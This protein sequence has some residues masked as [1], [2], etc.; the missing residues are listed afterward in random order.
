MRDAVIVSTARSPIG[1]AYK[2]AFNATHAPTLAGHAIRAAVARSG[3]SPEMIDDVV[4]G[5]GLQQG[6]QVTIARTAALRAGLPASVAAMSLD[7]QCAS[8]LMA[9]ATAAKQV[10]V[11]RMEVV[12]A[13]GVES[14][15][16][17]QTKEMR[18]T[19]D[20]ELLAAVPDIYMPMLQTAEVVADRYGIGRDVQDAYALQS[21]QRTAVALTRGAFDQEIVP[22]DVVMAQTDRASG[23]IRHVAL[24]IDADE[25]PRPETSAEGLATRNRGQR[26]PTFRR[27]LRSN[28]HGGAVGGAART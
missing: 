1:R 16:L 27:C 6:S 10:I 4:I 11:D 13:G 21:Q 25:G 26:Q 24:R 20:P 15:S 19:P 18:L 9:I 8:G 23:E 7:R 2:G 12:L 28:R 17:V 22:I 5:A 14:I 3:V